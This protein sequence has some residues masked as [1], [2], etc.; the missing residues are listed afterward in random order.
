MDL[1]PELRAR[2]DDLVRTD[3]VVLFMKG[4]RFSPGCGFSAQVVEILGRHLTSF[5]AVNVLSD[6]ALRDGVKVYSE[7]PTFPQ[8]YVDGELVGGCDI[9]RQLD[10]EGELAKILGVTP[11]TRARTP[12]VTVTDAAAEVFAQALEE[13]GEGDALRLTVPADFRHD[14]VIEPVRDDDLVIDGGPIKLH[15]DPDSATR[16]D[17]TRIDYVT[18]P[19][20]GFRIDNPQAPP[21]VVPMAPAELKARLEA[22]EPGRLIDVRTEGERATARIEGSDLLEHE[23]MQELQ[24]LPRDTPLVFY[25]HHGMRS[26]QAAQHFL[27]HGFKTVYNLTGGIDRWSREVDPSVPRY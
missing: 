2:I 26:Q 12:T 16:V 19:Q 10:D 25:C 9:V 3:R 11:G 6:P 23:V 24:R 15:L 1:S 17:G 21:R 13:A 18:E 7:W 20:P 22:S 14:L 27:E 4:L 5:S 8:L